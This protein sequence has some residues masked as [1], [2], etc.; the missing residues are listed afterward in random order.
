MVTK[1]DSAPRD[2]KTETRIKKLI[3]DLFLAL[4]KRFV[5]PQG[6]RSAFNKADRYLLGDPPIK[7]S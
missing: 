6:M 4:P 2:I 5:C 3:Y 7:T 1:K